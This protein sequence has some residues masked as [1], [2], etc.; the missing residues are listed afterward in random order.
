[1]RGLRV[2]LVVGLVAVACGGVG[3]QAE[4]AAPT[5]SASASARLVPSPAVTPPNS[6]PTAPPPGAA[7]L[8]AGAVADAGVL[9]V[10]GADDGIY[11]YDGAS[12]ALARV[13]GASTLASETAYGP[14]VLGRHGGITLLRWDGTTERTC[15]SGSFAA[16][17]VRGACAF[18]GVGG[19]TAVYVDRGGGAQILLPA[20]WG[21]TTFA[22]SPDGAELAIV[23]SERRPDP[24]PPLEPLW[25]TTLWQL[26]PHGALKKIFDSPSGMSSLY[27]LKWSFDR[28]ILVWESMTTSNSLAAD[29]VGTT[30]H[31]VNVDTGA[32]VDL[33]TLLGMRAWAQWSTDGRLAFVSGGGRQTW[34]N[35]QLVVL[36]RDGTR[37]VIA[38]VLGKPSDGAS[39]AIAPAWQPVFAP[40]GREPVFGPPA[41]L[42]WI[43]GPAAGIEASPDYFRAAGPIAQR[44]AMLETPGGRAQMTCPGL[45]TEGVRWSADASAALLLC[46]APGVEQHALQVW[47]APIGGTP[48]ALVTGLGDLGFGYYGLQPSL[49]DIV[50]WSLADR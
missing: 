6:S 3:S 47:Y 48:R 20:D 14:Y 32:Y 36:E 25:R 49:F 11:R 2:V 31:V 17:S 12:G 28:R 10:W 39:A 34:G 27:G 7:P 4:P 45:M 40:P 15:P 18:I 44:V 21:A 8:S 16:I 9:Y 41:R 5:P 22:W 13:W 24:V 1:M 23:R 35:K 30:L 43:E 42:A 19:D 46:R 33:G 38:G 50:A 37:R 29:G 26:D